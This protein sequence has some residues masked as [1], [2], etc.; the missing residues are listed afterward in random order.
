MKK[1]IVV[2]STLF[3]FLN[4]F[5]QRQLVKTGKN[6]TLNGKVVD[7]STK[8]P[9]EYATVIV[10]TLPENQQLTGTVTEKDGTFMIENLPEGKFRIQIKFIGYKTH[11]I[12]SI[13]LDQ[14]NPSRNLDVIL[15]QPTVLPGEE[16]EIQANRPEF[17]YKIDRK[18][19]N[20]GQQQTAISGTAVDVLTNVPSVTVDVEG[21]VQ[22][23]GSSSF[24]VL[25]DNRPT[26]LDPNET[27]QQTPASAIDKIEIIT[28][29]SAK[30]DPDGT[31]G[32]INLILKKSHQGG[33]T[34]TFN[35]NLGLDDLMDRSGGDF[36]VT[37]RIAQMTLYLGADYNARSFPGS[38]QAMQT[39]S[40]GDTALY[41]LSKG[42]QKRGGE[43]YGI[44]GG[45]DYLINEK[46]L[47][48][49]GF[50]LGNR[51]FEGNFN[52]HYK[53]WNSLG[54]WYYVYRSKDEMGRG[55]N[56]YS[57]NVDFK[58]MFSQS[59]HELFC[60][61]IIG[62]S[63]GDEHNKNALFNQSDSLTEGQRA[64]ESGPSNDFRMKVDY[65]LPLG[66]TQKI[67]AGYQNRLGIGSEKTERFFYDIPSSN[68]V[69]QAPF[70]HEIRYVHNIHSMY[71]TF[72]SQYMNLGYQLGLRGE[73]TGREIELRD[74][75]QKFLIDRW[76]IFP[77][78]HFSY[79]FTKGKQAMASYTR[80]I[81]R[82]REWELEPFE[83][84]MDAYNVRKGN[85]DLKPEFIDSY[86]ATF[87]S[88]VGKSLFSVEMYYRVTH[89]KI[90]RTHSLYAPRI[91]LHS[92]DNIGQDYAFGSEFMWN[93]DLFRF[94]NVNL[95]TNV[96][97]YWIKGTLFGESFSRESFNWSMRFNHT[98]QLEKSTRL[99]INSIYNSPSVSSQGR[100][101][102]NFFVNLGLRKEFLNKKLS[103][104][105]QIQDVFKT[106]KFEFTNHAPNFYSSVKMKRKA[107]FLT[108]TLTY[109]LNNNQKKE[110][111]ASTE[112]EERQEGEEEMT[113]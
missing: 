12:E 90:E 31:A 27:L 73:Y 86:E 82:P 17:E 95:M 98:F 70:S 77:T 46:N 104:T 14:A 68:Y 78:L 44:R 74:I 32:I 52:N 113:F 102:K 29:P 37:Y 112:T 62:H 30:Y 101:E 107:P 38:I 94:W 67:Q 85:P 19:I 96:Y 43:R 2:L 111:K 24:T 105:F 53:E 88:T 93:F 34:G 100:R 22:L 5:A 59:E 79:T 55:G 42:D 48:S 92:I 83:T 23:R 49:V 33:I 28:N 87:Q 63:N 56:F 89:N 26:P 18:I 99:Q 4:L 108:L 66:E 80:R 6:F 47:V 57:T 39:T 16:V 21:N 81:E 10:F 1:W 97:Q 110:E 35:T 51:S 72:S 13:T 76:D 58:H 84:W 69:Y 60:Q 54:E 109:H 25:I 65:T 50:R 7:A 91:T 15:L 36:L 71:G 40:L 64:T 11:E 41:R 20:V 75:A 9:L 61:L 3:I 45:L 8:A 106:Q 103:A